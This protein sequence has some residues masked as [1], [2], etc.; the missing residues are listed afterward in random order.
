MKRVL[1]YMLLIAA[2]AVTAFAKE[3]CRVQRVV[4]TGEHSEGDEIYTSPLV[5]APCD[6]WKFA[7]EKLVA[8]YENQGF[9]SAEVLGNVDS[10]GVLTVE[11]RRGSAFVWA[12][13]ENLDSSGTMPEVFRKLAGLTA[14]D[15]VRP[16]DLERA[17]NRLS[18]LG[19]FQQTAPAQMFRDP[20]RNRIVPVFSMRGAAVSEAEALLTYSSQ[21]NVWEGTVDVSLMNILGTARDLQVI[22]FT[23]ENSRRLEGFYKEPWI[24]GTEW[25]LVARGYFDDDS[26]TRDAYGEI[27]ITRNIGFDFTIGV[28]VGVGDNE[29]TSSL[30]ISYVSLDRFNL[31]RSGL[32]M[33][34]SAVWN[35]ARPDSLDKYLRLK[36]SIVKFVPLY[37][38]WIVRAGGQA[39]GLFATDA[40]L[41]RS[42]YFALGGMN[43]FKAMD[44]RFLRTRA[45]GFSE[46]AL[47]WQDGYDLSVE[48]FYQPGLIRSMAPEHGW[49][50]EHEY[51]LAF[52][53]YRK[54][55]S[56][57]FYYALRNGEN[58]LD[59]IVGV[60]VKTLF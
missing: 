21:N 10:A 32:R 37:K 4:W 23:S 14:G 58:Y 44:Y 3:G 40:K 56:I 34:G 27:G 60:G 2:F 49:K 1:T 15:P 22:G 16:L 28:F 45:Y 30:E 39:G 35:M 41:D 46:F 52:T 6:S 7:A 43:D 31:P 57:N 19:Y 42:D 5:G 20:S 29:K 36:A 51:G 50:E 54:N 55:W 17:E 8:D 47:L 18:R 26:S 13:S 33:D 9:I 24:L 11:L 59:G 53:Q 25:N 48:A 38:N 12:G